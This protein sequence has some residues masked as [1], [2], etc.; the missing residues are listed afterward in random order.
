MNKKVLL[1]LS[2]FLVILIA[3]FIFYRLFFKSPNIE[4]N[5]IE[6]IEQNNEVSSEQETNQIEDIIYKSNYSD[7]N[8]YIIKAEYGKFNKD[9]PD[10]M[11]LINVTGTIFLNE[12]DIVEISSKRASYNS[13]NYNT[14]FYQE[15]LVTFGDHKINSDNFDL[16]FDK[17]ISTIYN[18]VIYKN[19]NTTLHADKIDIDLITKDSK[20]YMLDKSK[21]VKI[22][23]LN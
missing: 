12:N 23:N 3:C 11:F 20:I 2:L 18:N 7:D 4:L 13:E 15:V 10:L 9:N 5:D 14:N 8:Q 19:L 17:K 16:L 21:K 6:K 1:Q 22:K